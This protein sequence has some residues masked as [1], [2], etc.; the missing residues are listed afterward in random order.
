M[1]RHITATPLR[2]A[3]PVWKAGAAQASKG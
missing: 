3:F 1:I 2:L